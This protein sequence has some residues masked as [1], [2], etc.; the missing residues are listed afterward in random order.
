MQTTIITAT[1]N[2]EAT[3]RHCIESVH[4]Q[5]V[6]CEHVIVDGGST[7]KTVSII[8]SYANAHPDYNLKFIPYNKLGIAAAFNVGIEACSGSIVAILNA[9]DWYELDAVERSIQL[10]QANPNAAYTYGSTIYY[11]ENYKL[12][13]T[14]IAA[15]AIHRKA[16]KCMPFGHITSFVRRN[17]YKE[18]GTYDESK[19]IAMDMEFYAR[20]CNQGLYGVEVPGI[21]GHVLSGGVSS[22][23][24]RR[25]KEAF[26]ITRQYANTATAIANTLNY[27]IR[28]VIGSLLVKYS[29]LSRFFPAR[30]VKTMS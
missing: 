28:Q 5:T 13:V 10:L 20:L 4:K 8:Q 22:N 2:A 25:T 29:W 21:I 7:D 3:I 6:P 9:D 1:L 23:Y 17:I 26:V 18:Y 15:N 24:W 19:K 11:A 14:P 30:R 27:A 16:C 12:R